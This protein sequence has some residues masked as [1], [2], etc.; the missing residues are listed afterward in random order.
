MRSFVCSVGIW[1]LLGC[2]SAI[3]PPPP[4]LATATDEETA[5][6]PRRPYAEQ[7]PTPREPPAAPA[8][9]VQLGAPSGS[10]NKLPTLAQGL[11]IMQPLSQLDGA[12]SPYGAAVASVIDL[13]QPVDIALDVPGYLFLFN[14]QPTWSFRVRSP[15]AVLQGT[16]GLTLQRVSTGVWNIALPPPVSEPPPEPAPDEEE[17]EE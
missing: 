6:A 7:M 5:P 8:L 13:S 16:T 12:A 3:K 11:P 9:W 4:P 17:E 14:F 1:G 2:A 15:D 10:L